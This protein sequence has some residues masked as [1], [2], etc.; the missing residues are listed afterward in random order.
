MLVVS[1]TKVYTLRPYTLKSISARSEL[2]V[3]TTHDT[4]ESLDTGFL[5]FT[6][7]I[8][9]FRQNLR[10]QEARRIFARKPG[11]REVTQCNRHLPGHMQPLAFW[12]VGQLGAASCLDAIVPGLG[13]RVEEHAKD[14]HGGAGGAKERH[15]VSE[16]EH[17]HAREMR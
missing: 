13:E 7:Y 17:L 6:R 2:N 14:G 9:H 5:Y 8:S 1:I 4:F 11:H 15:R 10:R 12:G 16:V 3:E